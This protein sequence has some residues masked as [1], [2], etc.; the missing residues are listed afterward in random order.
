MATG[1]GLD[2]QLM[3]AQESAWGT[4][5]TVTRG[6]EFLSES[7][8]QEI[9][10]TDS[11]GLRTGTTFRRTARTK[12]ARISVSG[13]IEL[14]IPTLGAGLLVKHMLGSSVTTPTL[15]AASAYKQVHTPAG[16][17]GLGLTM[18]VG[19]PE[20]VSPYTVRPFTYEGCKVTK[21]EISL[22]D[23]GLATLKLT[24]DGQAESTATALAT[25]SFLANSAVYSFN[26]ASIKLGGTA[27]T[28]SGET[29]ITGGTQMSTVAKSITISG[30]NSLATDRYG[31]GNAGQKKEQLQN[32]MQTITVKL[33]SEFSKTE[34]YDLYTAGTPTP[35]QFDLTG[36]AIGANNFLFSV[37]LPSCILK[38]APPSVNGPDIV[39]MSTE[40]EAEWDETNP[41]IQ[42]KIVSTE[43]TN[44]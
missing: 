15:V 18:Q 30:D 6:Y 37:I 13:D 26:Q 25:A 28:A 22:K 36:A 10:Y 24:V 33:D 12:Q 32:G 39:Q 21:W 9:T 29:T 41:P 35:I 34:L 19:R 42:I 4:A 43:S 31:I 11:A 3:V 16:M 5:V 23:G 14:E 7:L 38:K 17:A 27:A 8:N 44:I 1:S 2:A 40:W 20:P